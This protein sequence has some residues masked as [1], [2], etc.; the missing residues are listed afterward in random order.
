LTTASKADAAIYVSHPVGPTN[1]ANTAL[2]EKLAE[3]GIPTIVYGD[4]AVKGCWAKVERP[5]LLADILKQLA[6][7]GS[8]EIPKT[9]LIQA[10]QQSF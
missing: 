4:A 2:A 6:K 3:K 7:Q 10:G 8:R 5:S 1:A 9:H